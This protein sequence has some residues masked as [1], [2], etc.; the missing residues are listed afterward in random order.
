[1]ELEHGVLL[2]SRTRKTTWLMQGDVFT[3]D[4]ARSRLIELDSHE[5]YTPVS[6]R[7][8]MYYWA[9]PGKVIS[10]VIAAA[11]NQRGHVSIV[12]G[13]YRAKKVLIR[14][15]TDNGEK[16]V[17][18]VL[19]QAAKRE[20]VFVEQNAVKTS[21]L[22]IVY[23]PIRNWSLAEIQNALRNSTDIFP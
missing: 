10:C 4:E 3:D 8:E 23:E 18:Y 5:S 21:R 14:Y 16:D 1:M 2:R 11:V 17:F 6:T 9:R 15:M 19:V 12:E 22:G 7:A 13:G 20:S